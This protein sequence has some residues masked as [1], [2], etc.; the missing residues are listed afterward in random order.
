MVGEFENS[1]GVP[2]MAFFANWSGEYAVDADEEA[3][4]LLSAMLVERL[5]R[6]PVDEAALI[7]GA[8]G[9]YPAF[10]D[11]VLR[12]VEHLEIDL[13]VLVPCRI[14]G[15][16]GLI[17]ASA[18]SVTLHP[19]AAIGAA[20]S[21]LCVVPRR[22]LD[23]S[24]FPHCPVDPGDLAEMDE[25]QEATVARLANDRLIRRQ[26]RRMAGHLVAAADVGEE[27]AD[28][29]LETTLGD[30]MSVG[31]EALTDTGIDARVAPEPLAEQLEAFVEWATETLHL[32]ERPGDR[33]EVSD[34]LATEVEFEPAT[35]IPAAAIIG[36]DSVWLHHLDTG[37]P[38]PDAPRLQGQWQNWDPEE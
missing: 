24:L 6:E 18:A 9:G 1:L 22:D 13:Q 5:R 2:T 30:G 35:L 27:T 7:I 21:G 34:D 20:D 36:V 8:R 11:A 25:A 15:M 4:R 3:G 28:W 26:Q 37:S 10:A 29:L 33:F 14:D 31:V 17:A 12:T 19:G 32:F 23:A 16:A 38:D